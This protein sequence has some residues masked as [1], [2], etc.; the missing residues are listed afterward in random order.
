MENWQDKITHLVSLIPEDYEK[1]EE[2]VT[3]LE[4]V[5]DTGDTWIAVVT[6]F[7]DVVGIEPMI[8]AYT[9]PN[10]SW[11]K[12]VQLYWQQFDGQE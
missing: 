7:A 5:E 8:E 1:Y 11:Q 12:S 6:V 10:D 3:R 9:S 4:S 2:L